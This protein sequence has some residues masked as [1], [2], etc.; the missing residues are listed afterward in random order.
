[1]TGRKKK[2]REATCIDLVDAIRL[3][4]AV[5]EIGMVGCPMY[6]KKIDDKK[7]DSNFTPVINTMILAKNTNKLGNSEVN[8]PK[9]L[10]YLIEM[11]IVVR[12]SLKEYEENP[13]FI[14]AKESISPLVLDKNACEVLISLVKN[15]LPSVMIP[16][17]IIG[18]SMPASIIGSMIVNNAEILATMT[19]IR[20]IVPDAVVGGESMTSVMDMRKGE[21]K[22]NTIDAIKFDAAMAQLL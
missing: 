12:G 16:M 2:K 5:D 11:E 9:Q 15:G 1:M 21:I 3:G 14:T 10:K 4:H 8:S 22:F 20:S 17:P 13:C 18:A 6:C 7:I 19:A